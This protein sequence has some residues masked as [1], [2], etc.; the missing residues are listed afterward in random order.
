[1]KKWIALLLAASALT[2][3]ACNTV[4]GI[5]RD[6]EATGDAIEDAAD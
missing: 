1:M 2:L 4:Q 6:V 3:S 5:G